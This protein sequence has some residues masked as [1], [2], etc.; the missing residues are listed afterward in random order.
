MSTLT[1]GESDLLAILAET[2]T[3]EKYLRG[4]D[5]HTYRNLA[6]KGL[7]EPPIE[8]RRSLKGK[9]TEAGRHAAAVRA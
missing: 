4:A 3:G 9:I 6:A 5:R 2:D 1:L 7:T 8:H